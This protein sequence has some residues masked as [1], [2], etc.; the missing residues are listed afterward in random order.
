MDEL[1]DAGRLSFEEMKIVG[2]VAL[3]KKATIHPV[4]QVLMQ[5]RRESSKPGQRSDGFKVALA[6]EGGGMR[7]CVAA[8]M[9]AAVKDAGFHDCFDAVYGSSA[10]SLI[11]AYWIANQFGMPQ[12]GCSLYYDLLTDERAKENFIDR[13]QILPL[14][15]LRWLRWLMPRS[16]KETLGMRARRPLLN[17]PYLLQ[18]CVEELRPLD[19]EA[20]SRNEALVPL[21][22]VASDV[23]KQRAVVFDREHG[24]WTSLREMTRCMTASMNLP[25]IAEP[26]VTLPGLD[27][28][29]ADAQLYEPIPFKS[30]VEDGFTHV[31]VLRT[32]PDQQDVVP[33]K[34]KMEEK[35]MDHFF[36]RRYQLP[37]I[38]D[39]LV[40]QE[41]KK[42]YA[43]DILALN[44]AAHH[45]PE[46]TPQLLAIALG[47]N[48]SEI[49]RLECR[50]EAIFQGVCDGY[51]SA[52]QALHPPAAGV[53]H[54]N[55]DE[56]VA[57]AFP[58]TI[59]EE[60]PQLTQ[61]S[62]IESFK[63]RANQ[64]KET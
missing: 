43:R 4:L 55:P 26:L 44:H 54:R 61:S 59:V 11:G 57:A 53:D 19:W 51:R 25:A 45:P 2:D 14:I 33:K 13:S 32:R 35:M 58:H 12:Y 18:T 27:S 49:G 40:N 34:S 63:R 62:W 47:S 46:D 48:S 64:R 21:K 52:W 41:H 56:A 60:T 6:I 17:L 10:G 24:H 22:I 3:D 39:Y 1:L 7:G 16:I 42:T 28:L 8:G 50:R 20:F 9:A 30:A 38:Y 36:L 37:H 15:G 5:R 23:S 31:L 29:L